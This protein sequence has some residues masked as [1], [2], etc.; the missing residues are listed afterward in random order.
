MRYLRSLLVVFCFGIFGLGSMVLNFFIF[1]LINLF[2]KNCDKTGIYH[3]IIRCLWRFFLLLL[4]KLRLIKLDIKDMQALENIKGKI[5]VA[6]HPS[7]IDILILVALIPK[8]TG[9]TKQSMTKNFI[10]K[11]LVNSIFIPNVLEYE[12][13]MAKTKEMLDKGF[14]VIIFPMGSRH[15]RG[16]HLKIKKGAATIALETNKNIV[17]VKMYTDKD[18]LFINQPFY[19]GNNSVVTFFI[20]VLPDIVTDGERGESEIIVKK[21]ITKQI[22]NSLYS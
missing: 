19:D 9:F 5:V 15:R 18:F 14:N 16:E 6:T 10:I 22:E 4:I 3:A 11:N 21:N 2:C 1:P 20:E 12:E 17:P 8:S 7:F 13:L